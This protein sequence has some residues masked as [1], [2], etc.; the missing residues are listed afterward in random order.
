VALGFR[1]RYRENPGRIKEFMEEMHPQVSGSANWVGP[2]ELGVTTNAE[3][4]TGRATLGRAVGILGGVSLVLFLALLI[5]LIALGYL[6][7]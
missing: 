2:R 3:P 4:L 7:S 1:G 5:V 6:G